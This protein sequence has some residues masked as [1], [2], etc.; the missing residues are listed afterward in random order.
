MIW[1][2]RFIQFTD[3]TNLRRRMILLHDNYQKLN[4]KLSNSASKDVPF[5]EARF[6]QLV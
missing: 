6:T 1:M 2:N 3:N 5:L 4:C